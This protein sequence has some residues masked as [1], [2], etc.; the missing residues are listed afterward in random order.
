MGFEPR[1]INLGLQATAG[2]GWIIRSNR[3]LTWVDDR[4]A[5]PG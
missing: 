1:M 2:G 4:F 5:S 3:A